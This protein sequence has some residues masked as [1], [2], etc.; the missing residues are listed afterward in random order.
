[1]VRHGVG[2][3]PHHDL[4][5]A[6]AAVDPGLPA[7]RLAQARPQE[8]RSRPQV[9]PDG[10]VRL[11]RHALRHVAAVRRQRHRRCSPTSAPAIG[12]G[13]PARRRS[14]RSAS[15]SSSSASPSRCR[16]ARS[17]PG[18]PTP[19]RVRPPR[20]RRSSPSRRRPPASWPCCNSSSSASPAARR[21]RAAVLGAGRRL[22]DRRQPDRAAPD[23][24]R[25]HA[26]R[27]RASRRPATCSRRS[28]SP[29]HGAESD[30]R[31]ARGHR[32]L[33]RDL[34]GD[35]PRRVRRGHRRRPQDAFGRDRLATAGS[36]ST[37]PG[38][39]VA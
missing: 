15:S 29:A 9:L 37:R 24:H 14:S 26:W 27:T 23:Q 1:M 5:G 6:R 30:E 12:D 20:S 4:R 34:R 7:R 33:P 18:R 25:A 32:H 2:A 31:G 28:P 8:Q 11:G 39:T 3:R 36:S 35:E 22:D 17:T 16:R 10:R 38:L 21:L 13:R 19:T